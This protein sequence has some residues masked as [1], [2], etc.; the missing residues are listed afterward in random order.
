MSLL[1]LA[2]LSYFIVYDWTGICTVLFVVYNYYVIKDIIKF[3]Q[4]GI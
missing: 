3:I 1:L 4:L 2:S